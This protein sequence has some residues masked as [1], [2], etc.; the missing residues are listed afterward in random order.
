MER[1]IFDG[2]LKPFVL[3]QVQVLD[4]CVKKVWVAA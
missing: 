1:Y 3:D 4:V 2:Q